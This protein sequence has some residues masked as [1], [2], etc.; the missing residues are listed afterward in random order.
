MVSNLTDG[1][2]FSVSSFVAIACSTDSEG[3]S[4]KEGKIVL[5]NNCNN[6]S[7]QVKENNEEEKNKFNENLEL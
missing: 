3:V 6:P 7:E 5:F 4:W 2:L 1:L